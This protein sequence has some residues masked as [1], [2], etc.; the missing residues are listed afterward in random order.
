MYLTGQNFH[1]FM[2]YYHLRK[3]AA[4]F[5][6]NIFHNNSRAINVL[7]D[8]EL[9]LSR[10]S[11][12]FK[13]LL[14]KKPKRILKDAKSRGKKGVNVVGYLNGELG[15]GEGARMNVCC[16]KSSRI[17][18]SLVNI[19]TH[20]SSRKRDSSFAEFSQENPF[21]IN[22]MH[23]NADMLPKLYAEKGGNFFNHKYNIGYW[24]W[25]L[26][27]FP[28]EWRE[29]FNYCDE[30]WV[31]STFV[32]ASIAQ[33]SPIP[34]FCFPHAIEVYHIKQATRLSL[35]L[36]EDVF[37]FLFI[38]DFFS[39]FERKNPL[40]IVQA[41]REVFSASDKVSLVIKCINSF[42]N[43]EAMRRLKRAAVGLRVTIVDSYFDRD[44]VN[45]LISLTDAYV[46]LHRS[47]GFGLTLAEAM[48]LGKPVIATGYSGNM[49]FMNLNNSYLVKHNLVALKKDFG[50]YKK[51]NVWAEPDIQH[52][53]LLMRHVFDNRDEAAEVGRRAQED[54]KRTL[55]CQI[56][57]AR[58]K[59]RLENI[60]L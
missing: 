24:A 27:D 41:F 9:I 21:G 49:D 10:K 32:L 22:L 52:A 20:S 60:G 38:F 12:R 53:G 1:V 43:P 34:T 25:E 11:W 47:E 14:F 23:V 36:K 58:I 59:K 57:G 30:I 16:L 42:H 37:V 56:I 5:F 13:K 33:K 26:S 35:G 18:F 19:E 2:V 46:S 29:S 55:N 8:M 28:D 31:P 54:I 51:E 4:M 7:R 6:R 39:C 15:I 44:E 3:I 50:P 17:E 45:G 40:A 48:F